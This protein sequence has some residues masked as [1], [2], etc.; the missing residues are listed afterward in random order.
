MVSLFFFAGKPYL[1]KNKQEKIEENNQQCFQEMNQRGYYKQIK[2]L[3]TCFEVRV[4]C[5]NFVLNLQ[6]NFRLSI[7]FIFC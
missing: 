6:I 2:K 4:K 1:E 7:I 3:H 5:F